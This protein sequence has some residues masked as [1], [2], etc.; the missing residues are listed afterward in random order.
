MLD[1]NK[2]FTA[3]SHLFTYPEVQ[4]DKKIKQVLN[5]LVLVEQSEVVEKL[6]RFH[7]FFGSTKFS[8]VEEMFTRTFDMNPAC[9]LEI[10][11]H[12]FGEDYKRGEFLVLIRQSLAEEKIQ[13]SNELPDHL[14]HCLKLLAKLENED[15]REF[16]RAFI[17][18]AL[19]KIQLGCKDNEKNPYVFLVEALMILLKSLYKIIE[20]PSSSPICSE[21]KLNSQ[22]SFNFQSAGNGVLNNN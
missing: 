10:G 19:A 8:D 4:L 3:F 14:S 13:E 1:T 16:S 21:P 12:L 22:S 7:D 17:L 9:C 2:L 20:V 6:N 15:A 18:P 5:E 11:W